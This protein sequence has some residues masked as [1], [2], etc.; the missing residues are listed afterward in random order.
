MESEHFM[1]LSTLL[2]RAASALL[3]LAA[4]G[5]L[6]P[7]A[8]RA[9][10]PPHS[11]DVVVQ[12]GN[13]RVVTRHITFTGT[14]SGLQ[15][16]RLAGLPLVEKSGGVCRID[17]TG[18]ASGEDCFCACPPPYSPC[19]FWSYQR[20]DGHAWVESMQGAGAT[21]VGDGAVEGW[22]WGRAIPPV[23]EPVLGGEAG[24]QWLR[25]QQNADG[26]YGGSGGNAGATIDTLLAARAFGHDAAGWQS[27]AGKSLVDALRTRAASYAKQGTAQIGKLA[28]GVAAADLDPRAFGG[29][30]LVISMTATLDA[31]T[32]AY[33]A[34]NWDHA[35]A[36]LGLRA[37]GESVPA[38][39]TSLL[40]SRQNSDGGWGFATPGSSDIDSTGLMLQALAAAGVPGNNAA[41][42]KAL[43]FLDT[44]QKSDG[45]FPNAPADTGSN[46][47]STAFAVQGILAS[48]ADPQAARW[49]PTSSN[50]ISYLLSLQ[51]PEGALT[52]GGQA[53]L[54]ATQQAIPALAG[55]ALPFLSRASAQR[56]ALNFIRAQQQADGSF[57]GFGTGSTI[58][59]VLAIDAA[60]GK[61]QQF[62]S[63][64]GKRPLDFLASKAATYAAGSAAASGKLLA[65]VVA[66]DADPRHFAGLNLVISTTLRYDASTGAFGSSTF[67]QAWAMIGLAAAG[68]T[69][70][71]SATEHLQAIASAG[72]GWG[73]GANDLA[74][75]ADSTGLALQALA[76]AHAQHPS[77]A[78]CTTGPGSKDPA[79]MAGLAFLRTIQ[80]PDGGFPGFGGPTSASSTGLALQG[81]AAF[82]EPARALSW[83]KTITD[84]TVSALT[85]RN[86]VD[87]LLD[88]QTPA[89]GFPGFGGPN[90]P[91]ATYQALPG[92]LA[93]AFPAS[94]RWQQFVPMARR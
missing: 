39:A 60:G 43:A 11:A 32:G 47:N 54:L 26:S 88:L 58:D 44:V 48:G 30:N 65:G 86:P 5:A 69:L 76:A 52:F 2:R 55:R 8:A 91:D 94:I 42:T 79:V 31:G 59:A 7:A 22:A 64:A 34:T 18:C 82:H 36:M 20:W 14:I 46:A 72:G 41:V 23:T 81:L 38:A 21:T 1:L 28:L 92:L 49:K 35:F 12:F 74:P 84:G 80:N 61:P 27:S 50:P 40:T 9:A 62:A 16:L 87:T 75:D 53:S 51:Q 56:L 93:R 25:P 19:L 71:L 45:G 3:L 68:Y 83:T 17:D 77:A 6:L 24:L 73:F 67:D 15:A 78:S 33:G 29:L 57:A 89:G 63:S 70:P 90:D 10:D 13:G 4:L 85:L 66:A 37:A